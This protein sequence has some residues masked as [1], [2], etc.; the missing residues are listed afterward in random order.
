[1]GLVLLGQYLICKSELIPDSDQLSGQRD[2]GAI[3]A[4]L[5]F[6]QERFSFSSAAI[7]SVRGR[8][9]LS[10]NHRPMIKFTLS[11][12]FVDPLCPVLIVKLQPF[13]RVDSLGCFCH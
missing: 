7:R 8:V 5:Q 12:D 3:S 13:Q 10:T 2:F 11:F 4:N 1:M 6:T 9:H